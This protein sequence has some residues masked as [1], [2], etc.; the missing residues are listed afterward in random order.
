VGREEMEERLAV[1]AAGP[2]EAIDK[3]ERFCRGE[4]VLEEGAAV[5]SDRGKLA[6]LARSWLVGERIDWSSLH[7]GSS[8]GSGDGARRIS[9]PTYPFERKKYWPQVRQV[10]GIPDVYHE[11][12]KVS[13]RPRLIL[14]S[15]DESPREEGVPVL[16]NK[17]QEVVLP[18]KSTESSIKI[19]IKEALAGVLYTG[20]DGISE[21]KTF[22]DLGL[23]S[24]LAIE[25]SKKLG[26]I[27]GIELK[28]NILYSHPTVNQLTMH[29]EG[30]AV[31]NS[32]GAV[33]SGA[34]SGPATRGA[35][36]DTNSPNYN[37]HS[38]FIIHHST[39]PPWPPEAKN[40]IAIIGLAGRF[41]GAGDVEQFWQNLV[42]GIDSIVEVPA[43]R[44]GKDV[45]G[46]TYRR[47]GGFLADV[48]CFDPLFFNISP[49]EAEV[50][51][52]QQRVFLEE[53]WKALE[54]AGYPDRG[55]SNKRCGVFVGAA[56]NDYIT[57]LQDIE[58]EAP[59]HAVTA[60]A[61]SVLASRI[62]YHL[63]MKGA[64]FA[65]DAACS[66][67]LAAIQL[68]CERILDGQ[69]EMALAGGVN[70]L[71]TP[72]THRVLSGAGMLS[73]SS[74]H[75]AF[76][77]Q[78]DGFV[79]GEAVVVLVLKALDRA[80]AD[81]DHIYGVIKAVG[82]NQNGRSNGI[83]APS[84]P[85]QA[86][87]ARDLYLGAGIDP[88]VVTYVEA[89]GTG[90]K[91]GDSIEVAALAEVYRR[92]SGE[93]NYCALGAVK[94]NVGHTLAAAGAVGL[95]KVL[96]ALK[97]KK[98]PANLHFQTP[99]T[100]IDFS[101]GAFYVNRALTDWT[102]RDGVPRT[103]AVNTFGING[104][105]AHLVVEEAPAVTQPTPDS[106]PSYYLVQLSA[107][108]REALGRKIRDLVSWLEKEG[109][110]HTISDIAYTLWVG[111]SH[112]PV[113]TVFVVKET[114]ELRRKLEK[115]LETYSSDR[116]S[117]KDLGET[118]APP[119]TRA[120]QQGEGWL[121][122]S[123]HR[124]KLEALAG[125]FLDG[126]PLDWDSLYPGPGNRRI[127]LPVYPF[128]RERYWLD[129]ARPGA[130]L[131]PLLD[132]NES[133]LDEQCFRKVFSGE[134]FVFTDHCYD[135]IKVL[136]G[137]AYVEMARAAGSLANPAQS[138]VIFK[139]LTWVQPLMATN[140]KKT[141]HVGL[142]PRGEVV[143][144]E[145][146]SPARLNKS[147]LGV[148]GAIFQK[149][150]LVAEGIKSRQ[151]YAQGALVYKNQAEEQEQAEVIPIEEIKKRALQRTGPE[152]FYRVIQTSGMRFGPAFQTIR[153]LYRGSNEVLSFFE[154]PGAVRAGCESF[155]IHPS[156]LDAAFQTSIGMKSDEA[157]RVD[158]PELP[159]MLDELQ[160]IKPLTQRGYAYVTLSAD[161]QKGND[162]TAVLDI[163]V[164]DETG[165]VLVRMKNYFGRPIRPHSADFGENP[166]DRPASSHLQEKAETYL[167]K[168]LARVAKLP[169][170][171]IRP[172]ERLEKYGID[173]LMI[174]N[175]NKEMEQH[176]GKLPRTLF[177]EYQT[178]AALAEYM[179]K[180]HRE[181]I[182]EK[183]GATATPGEPVP[184]IGETAPKS[185]RLEFKS[186]RFLASTNLPARDKGGQG[187]GIAV[188][189]L[190]G[191]YPQ[192]RNVAEFWQNLCAGKD[193]T[194]EIP[195][196]RWDHRE[197]YDPDPEKAKEGKIYC[198]WGAFLDDED[199][200]DPLFF[201]ISPAEAETID[202]QERILLETA[203][204]ALEDAGYTRETLAR[205]VAH[206]QGA[207][208]GVFI[209]ST[210]NTYL[211][212]GPTEWDRGNFVYPGTYPW[213]LSNRISYQFN[214]KGPSFTIDTGCS[215]SL[216]ALHLACES[217]KRGECQ[218]AMAG[219]VNLYL[220]YSKYNRLCQWK[221]LSPTGTCR[222]FGE[223]A[224]GF[225]PGEG[226]GAV[227]LK[228]LAAA[229]RDNDHIYA[230]IK[231][232][233]MNHDGKTNGYTVPNP[234]A[235]AEVIAQG[236]ENAG[237]DPRTV[238]YLEAHGTGTLL[239]D[240]IEITGIT[241]AF[242]EYTRDVQFCAL[243]SAKANVGHMEGAA[244]IGALT[245]IL[246][247]LKNRQLV[248]SLHSQCLNPNIDFA[249]S[250]V[251]VQQELSEWKQ[252]VIGEKGSEKKYP[253]RA[254]V[255][256]FGAGGAN[257]HVLVEE[258]PGEN[259]PGQRV[260]QEN[261]PGPQV[262]V[263][264]ARNEERL[265]EYA[266]NLAAYLE[267]SS[268]VQ[269][270]AGQPG[271]PGVDLEELAYTLQV[272]RE[273]MN[274]RLAVM[275]SGPGE[276][277]EKLSRFSRGETG[278]EDLYKG[279]PKSGRGIS[280]LLL[281]GRAGEE[282]LGMLI[283]DRDYSRLAQLWVSGVDID[284]Q[285]FYPG[286]A[287]ARVSLPT[288]PFARE[289][290]WFKESGDLSRGISDGWSRQDRLH[291]MLDS[292]NS[293]FQ[294]QKFSIRFTGNEFYLTDH[295]VADRKVLPGVAFIEMAR[296]AGEIAAGEKVRKIKN[297]VWARPVVVDSDAGALNLRLYPGDD[298][299]EF[300]V[301]SE[302]DGK[303]PI[304]HA[305]GKLVYE[306]RSR[307][308]SAPGPGNMDTEAIMQRCPH[309]ME[310]GECYRL[311]KAAGLQYGPTFQGIRTLHYNG[312][313]ALA[314]IELPAAARA[315][316]GFAGFVLHPSLMDAALQTVIA[317]LPGKENNPRA[318][319]LPFT[320][321]EVEIFDS[322]SPDVLV[323]TVPA[324]DN[325]APGAHL[326]TFDIHILD[327]GGKLLVRL[328]D[329]SIRALAPQ[330]KDNLLQTLYYRCKWEESPGWENPPGRQCPPGPAEP[331]VGTILV[332]DVNEALR[333]ALSGR[334]PGQSGA[335]R[336]LLVKPGDRFL[337]NGSGVY[338]VNPGCF[339]DYQK[340]FETLEQQKVL[341]AKILHLWSQENF[342]AD[343]PALDLRL[344]RGFYSVFHISRV[345]MTMTRKLSGHV[346][347]IY[348]YPR[349]NGEIQ[350]QYAAVGGFAHTVRQEN[351]NF[352]YKTVELP[353]TYTGDEAPA[354]PAWVDFLLREFEEDSGV[355]I[356]YEGSRR[357]VRRLREFDLEKEA[358]TLQAAGTTL[359]LKE[360]GV[361]LVTG[362][363]GGL[364]LLLAQYL[365]QQVKA[366]LVLVDR[367]ELNAAKEAEIQKLQELGAEV[368]FIKA[369]TANPQ[370][371][372]GLMEQ[373]K[374]RYH[375]LNGIIHCAGMIHDAL[376]TKKTPE[377]MAQV[378]APKVHGAICLDEASQG[379]NLDFFVMYSS[380]AAILGNPG[381][382]DYAFANSFMDYYAGVREKRRANGQRKGKT[383]SINWPL[384][385]HG[386]MRIDEH[387]EKLMTTRM[388]MTPLPTA[389]GLNAF[390]KGLLPTDSQLAVAHGN[391][392]KIRQ[393]LDPERERLKKEEAS[394]AAAPQSPGEGNEILSKLQQDLG[395]IAVHILKINE[396]D[397][398]ADGDL[399]EY[400][401]DSIS[402]T[403]F[404][405]LIDA[406]YNL[407]I[408]PAVFFELERP[409]V[410]SLA[411]KLYKNQAGVFEQFFREPLPGVN[412]LA[413][414]EKETPA[415][416]WG[417]AEAP[418]LGT[419]RSRRRSRFQDRTPVKEQS[420]QPDPEPI[421]IIGIS[422]VMP[423]CENLEI[424]RERLAAGTDLITE[425][426]QERW[427][428]RAFAAGG[429]AAR[430]GGFMKEVDK[431][432]AEF[433]GIS[434]RE[435]ELM[436]P[437]QRIFL[438]VTWKAIEDAGYGPSALSG[439]RTGIFVG[440]SS[441][442]YSELLAAGPGKL[443]THESTGKAHSILA[444][445]ISYLLDIH[446]PSESIDTACSSSLVAIHQAVT[447]IRGGACEM[448]IAGGVNVMLTPKWFL[449]FQAA[450]MLSKDGRCKTF[451]ERANGYVRGEGAG[452]IF[453]KPLRRALAD[454]DHIY[455]VIKA[456]AENHGGRAKSLTAPNANAQAELLI[457]AYTKARIDPATVSYIE[458][459]GTGTSL[460]DPIEINGLKKAFKKLYED[461]GQAM[462][463]TRRCGIGSVKTNIGHLE[464]AAGIAG[465]L[466]VLLAMKYRELP[467]TVHFRALNP[468]I[469]L[470][471]SP[472][473][474]VDT[475][476]P[477]PLLLDEQNRPIPRRAGVSSFGFG[478]SNAHVALEEY[479]APAAGAGLPNET[480][481]VIVL[482]AKNE[483]RLKTRVKHMIEFL[484][485]P[486]SLE[487]GPIPGREAVETVSREI[488][489]AAADILK[490]KASE[491]DIDG[492]LEE[493]GFDPVGLARLATEIDEKYDRGITV[494]IF[495]KYSTIHSLARRLCNDEA[496]TG[497]GAAPPAA[498]SLPAVSL[499]DIAYTL[500]L[501]RE[502]M[503]ERLA[504]VVSGARELREKL[505]Q[506]EQGNPGIIDVYRGSLKTHREKS[507]YIPGSLTGEELRKIAQLWVSG[508]DIDWKSL[509]T[510]AIPMRVPLPVYPFERTRFW[511]EQTPASLPA[512]VSPAQFP[513]M[514]VSPPLPH[515]P[516]V[517]EGRLRT[518]L[519]QLLA[520]V[521]YLDSSKIDM[522]K[523]FVD[524]GLD[525]ILGLEFVNKFEK[526]FKIPL[527]ATNL[528]DYSTVNQL[529]KYVAGLAADNSVEAPGSEPTIG[530]SP[531]N[532][533]PGD[534]AIIGM[535]GR[536]P[537]ADHI[538][539]LWHNLAN[540]VNS[541]AEVPRERW[542]IDAYYDPAP[543]TPGKSYCKWGGF[544]RGVDQFDPLFF[545]I[546][547]AEAALLDPQQ[548]LFLEE[549]LKALEN[550]GYPA[551][552]MDN[553]KCG[554]YVG[555][556]G[557]NEYNP[558]HLFNSGSI[559]AA[560]I[561]YFLNLK[562]PAIS[563]DT[564][565]SSSLVAI[566]LACQSLL[567]GESEMM[568][569]GGV[570]LYLTGRP[571]IEMSKSGMLSP[572]GKCK[573]F[574]N[575]ADGFVPGE[576]V[577]VVV[578]KLLSNALR[579]NDHIYGV[580]KGSGVNQ[581]GRTNGIT[582]PSAKSQRDLELAVYKENGIDPGA[583]TYVEA[584]GTA[585]NLG[586]P[587][588][589]EALTEAF[590]QY[591]REKQYCAIGSIKTNFGHTSAAA[592]AAGVLKVLLAL[593][594]KKIP[595]SLNYREA[596][597]HIDFKNSP[598]YVN[599]QLVDW[600]SRPGQ[601]RRAA[602]SSFG[603][604]GTNAHLVIE[605]AP[606]PGRREPHSPKPAW[607]IPLSARTAESLT[608]KI[609]DLNR[610][611]MT[612][613]EGEGTAA[614]LENIS[615]TL[616]MG[617]THFPWRLALVVTDIVELKQK[618]SG[619]QKES[620]KTLG[621]IT[622]LIEN[623]APLD[624]ALKEQGEQ[625][626]REL[627]QT[628]SPSPDVA[629]YLEKL[630]ALADFYMKGYDLD[631]Q[632][633]YPVET[634][635][636]IPLP[637]YP[638][639]RKRYWKTG[640]GHAA[641][642]ADP[643]ETEKKLR[644][645]AE[646]LLA[647]ILANPINTTPI[648]TNSHK[649]G[650]IKLRNPRP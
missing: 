381:Q 93:K 153:E 361:Y 475:T 246:L 594:Y 363:S 79:L 374:K 301:D 544:L 102:V 288:Y 195:A 362:A 104:A 80:M 528:Y 394:A 207:N 274:E 403:E 445:R 35:K 191:R 346:R 604:S 167:K 76:D 427:D 465:L 22:L 313:E 453:L 326:N 589:V 549:T 130:R 198:K 142:Y 555:V 74:C 515:E 538:W 202:P 584:H 336:V 412:P 33:K 77:E 520:E 468:Y 392:A 382:C 240:P 400:G 87:L 359:P 84:A 127:S 623:P 300:E 638:F 537:G 464:A 354:A 466:K 420:E 287:P 65:V 578:L 131:H 321:G 175:L 489:R 248:P 117:I 417:E 181:K 155:G 138:P 247:Q 183:T 530:N 560:R 564:A 345:L 263:L 501:G 171:R 514:T 573:T 421:A 30:V 302:D 151:V 516:M 286:G 32:P 115:L 91:L 414:W 199:K 473:Y 136:P 78:A 57:R 8:G 12:M 268:M 41:P 641:D 430:W 609:A 479:P 322:L 245:K 328:K 233:A 158:P 504:L 103:A 157:L 216:I 571:Y 593:R 42:N 533:A 139:N 249:A 208:V 47:R 607:I 51:D 137:A 428:W 119:D 448:A 358:E 596:N 631:W 441:S 31:P 50:M 122:E 277:Q 129:A 620:A 250:P 606:E 174:I 169:V 378:L 54:D 99:N 227:L 316:E 618:I 128:E 44:W 588:E 463:T 452:A 161:K 525:S 196:R 436:D 306:N 493:L 347:L 61:A 43:G 478:G 60:N 424:F 188:I 271:R 435:A 572:E 535:S 278:I 451:D 367:A 639:A 385:Q 579:D 315:K 376:V 210:S 517:D 470:K 457:E 404:A 632:L 459:H 391:A 610:W 27:F 415:P 164:T 419:S 177:F 256:A 529:A 490:V 140:G 496:S 630:S 467:G 561:A 543:G 502:P 269:G 614:S 447:A 11:A 173:S 531:G 95:A 373:I 524:Q 456:T 92:D 511:I 335:P 401:F 586:D 388:G 168:I 85:A 145:I 627:R 254:G 327:T 230:V 449:V 225:I 491:I 486:G 273:A 323:Y 289:R 622:P 406:K 98:I 612:D 14:K 484:A 422:G 120:Q 519:K 333:D 513:P 365:A 72:Q 17:P 200:F 532:A 563:I 194:T 540:G 617:R 416:G 440:V 542:D 13:D 293:N 625:W 29:L 257:V 442:D 265:I 212:H 480:P 360:K 402:L 267:N 643:G 508:V 290:C 4:E 509:Y 395:K 439:T 149:S 297:I 89:H 411:Q 126:V 109:T 629:G 444:N 180:E 97:Y 481:Q 253:R 234:N 338:T 460:G 231:G 176:F 18:G 113:R 222:A 352:I 595:P 592:G 66:S 413:E 185:D 431:F 190:S 221:M 380:A 100:D 52:P 10:R 580:I 386:G 497:N 356:R 485:S 450:G 88:A 399:H 488:S 611:L 69:L 264:S 387:S 20:V 510:S 562:G 494:G 462:P 206:G 601:P 107:M 291:P 608:R 349:L 275:A 67:S 1:V 556:M 506:F 526:I 146:Y 111:R 147:F 308:A 255:S 75:R 217:L 258:W 24:I 626:L 56:G 605:E 348:I 223:G 337:E 635:R 446:G 550:A 295:V 262:I 19:K 118:S 94:T 45:P 582:A 408:T 364:G 39:Q 429:E 252:P 407:E 521:L 38:S 633:L 644:E 5:Q 276:L 213:S 574:D 565:C 242:R 310:S 597:R 96:M 319:Y 204:A 205:L 201:N 214:F 186:A 166:D 259:Q 397:F 48:D 25:L 303:Q 547:P 209:G 384:W 434:P 112:L 110:R 577:G 9:L 581:D 90:S 482:S 576:G 599:T 134:E 133:T 505:Q 366:R 279:N 226:V 106:A 165:Q 86:Q 330:G 554:V 324:R 251:Y 522:D 334:Y 587:I 332:F 393:A 369:D 192:A 418:P 590:R 272:G 64:S 179:I 305:Q 318:P 26:E 472:F 512:P 559:L 203:W 62:A 144:F 325:Q 125:L 455:A 71:T 567:R 292:N 37:H 389:A 469:D 309:V 211:L 281:Q 600:N 390:I 569:A 178:L 350:P 23:D 162:N 81:G 370:E 49:G 152:E 114:D 357:W 637:M 329:F 534:I 523:P 458:A 285:V 545:N 602:V 82:V 116:E 628:L 15:K 228:P 471:D 621:K 483:D 105:N 294:E 184:G 270:A 150:P 624:P 372:D 135:E 492:N 141:V 108:T 548:R 28:T 648:D 425:A 189:G 236:L 299:V 266:G 443:E 73:P 220:H 474:I 583:I 650:K 163:R 396:K 461:T 426:P 320:L 405:N 2:D 143:E 215:S 83:T 21:T 63:D 68:A 148:Q 312:K 557:L 58:G 558:Q 16:L 101:R 197:Y 570:T 7:T 339:T 344:E 239:G 500:Q 280:G 237:I 59:V 477:W 355:E 553:K 182:M 518:R 340:L 307:E 172:K 616:F 235:Q 409:S 296:A 160:V 646:M 640:P 229:L 311:F 243:G 123:N 551:A 219:G 423:Q 53:A 154:L 615:Y 585:T 645:K 260:K 317:L 238:S 3:L 298:A 34:F 282:F 36:E 575:N 218:L 46:E 121:K 507:G 261:T 598:F 351:S 495:S 619:I 541:I 487:P 6:G 568:L 70:V 368:I 499:Q 591:T 398:E 159:F 353:Q 546:S 55:M 432:D 283:K 224:D 193:S 40:N 539:D 603:Y 566:H 304:V 536:Y 613:G 634:R 156:L 343:K 371:I 241:K 454:H 647:R 438:E 476:M 132:S 433:F 437:Q 244:G 498:I 124:D 232:S 383:L 503:E 527:K 375:A 636:R 331:G 284:W 314:H 410:A 642:S 341:P 170:E 342:S 379:E 552:A 649:P 377:Q 187:E